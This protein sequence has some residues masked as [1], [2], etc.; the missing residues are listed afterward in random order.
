[1]PSYEIEVIPGLEDLAEEE[2]RSV[3]G[4]AVRG[5]GREGRISLRF[6]GDQ[7]LLR[8]LRTAVAVHLVETFEVPRPRGLLGHEHF[9]RMLAGAV[10]IVKTSP[11]DQFHTIRLS[12]AG[13]DSSVFERLR[14]ELASALE[15]RPTAPGEDGDLLIA[16]RPALLPFVGWQVLARLTPRPLSARAWRVC[17]LPGALNATVAS[18]MVRLT[19][20]AQGDRFLNLACGSATLLVE[21]RQLGAVALAV[22]CDTSLPALACAAE[23]LKASEL[24]DQVALVRADCAH[25]PFADGSFDSLVVDLPYGM[26]TE[27]PDK[28]RA[29]Y[30]PFLAEAARV[31]IS[32]GRLVAITARKGWLDAA[33]DE[34]APLWQRVRE[35]AIKIPFKSGAFPAHILVLRRG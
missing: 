12:A 9:T 32:G 18:A 10:G 5:R 30:A 16:V 24:A 22:G 29:L 13:G 23:N 8:G 14:T 15:L 25:L 31:A 1:M 34:A 35:V 33:I 11:P 28:A 19:E 27:T 21:R 6:D 4:V 7:K 2:L 17:N 26:L 20:P 3:R